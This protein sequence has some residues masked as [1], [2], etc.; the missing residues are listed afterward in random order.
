MG[1]MF[2]LTVDRRD[3]RRDGPRLNMREHLASCQRD[4]PSPVLPWDITAGDELQALYDDAAA[5]LAAA[6]ALADTGEWHV[7][8]GLGPVDLPLA[9]AVRESTGPA[10]VAAREAVQAAKDSD[11]PAVHGGAW[12]ERTGSVLDLV[13]AVRRR[14]T[15]SGF[16]TAALADTG[17]TQQQM[18]ARLGITQSSVSRRLDAALWREERAARTTVV[19][20]LELA[21]A[22]AGSED[23]AAAPLQ[24]AAAAAQPTRAGRGDRA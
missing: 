24:D 22:E 19:A 3:S 15:A 10:L 8:L 14:R 9:G 6:L 5:V 16:Q 2:A 21:D 23:S 17:L 7:G 20:L 1:S 11:S 13:C 12:A 4:L 18:A